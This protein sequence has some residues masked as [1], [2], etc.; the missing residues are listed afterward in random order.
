MIL[1]RGNPNDSTK[2]LLELINE[3]N[4][5]AGYKINAQKSTASLYTNNEVAERE[6]KRTNPFTNAP[7]IIK[8]L[9]INL[10]K[11][12]KDLYPVNYKTP[13]KEI[14]GVLGWP[15]QLNIQ[16]LILA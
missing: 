4:K 5:A 13:R 6:I 10:M 2:K 1:Y 11:E 16:L 8:Y 9:G 15:S 7:K 12:V 14:E 3:F